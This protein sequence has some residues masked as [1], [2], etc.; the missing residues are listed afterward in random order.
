M[1]GTDLY[2]SILAYD[3]GD[4]E[5]GD[6]MEKVWSV[7]PWVVNVRTGSMTDMGSAYYRIKQW[8]AGSMGAE[9]W[10]IHGRPGSWQ[11]G[12]A[13]VFGETYIGFATEAM[14]DR[15]RSAFGDLI[16]EEMER[17]A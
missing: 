4:K 17:A 1:T 14:L 3:Y 10:P 6:L 9:A 7:T 8:C 13:T 11:Y 15:F 16:I 12:S 2:R 5:R